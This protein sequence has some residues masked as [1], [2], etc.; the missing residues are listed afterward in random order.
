LDLR[1]LV[2]SL[3]RQQVNEF[4]GYLLIDG[5]DIGHSVV[6]DAPLKLLLTVA[7][8]IAAKRSQEHTKEEIIARDEADRAH[9]YG[10]LPHP[11]NPGE[12]V[13]VLATDEHTPESVR[14][15][16]YTLMTRTFPELPPL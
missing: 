14:D 2:T 8:D 7:P 15:H 6:P 11:D 9:K 13:I 3:V 10:A 12:N 1:V 5:R 4:D 16:V